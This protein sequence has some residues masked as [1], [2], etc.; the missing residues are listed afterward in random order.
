M[1]STFCPTYNIAYF[2]LK[3]LLQEEEGLTRKKI[4]PFLFAANCKPAGS[5]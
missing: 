2:W 5:L 3:R 1:N 4:A